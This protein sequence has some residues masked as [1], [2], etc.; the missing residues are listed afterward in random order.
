[1]ATLFQL[2]MLYTVEWGVKMIMN[3]E[4]VWK[5]IATLGIWL[6]NNEKP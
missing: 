6:Y 3:R 4:F 5:N 1:M 2:E